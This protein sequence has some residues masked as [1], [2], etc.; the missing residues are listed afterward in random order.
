MNLPQNENYS[1]IRRDYEKEIGSDNQFLEELKLRASTT[2]GFVRTRVRSNKRLLTQ[3]DTAVMMRHIGQSAHFTSM[4]ETAGHLRAV[5]SKNKLRDAI[6]VGWGGLA[7]ESIDGYIQDFTVGHIQRVEGGMKWVEVLNA[8]FS[9]SVLALKPNLFAKQMVSFVAYAADIPVLD[10]AAGLADFAKNPAEAIRVMSES[11][12]I[13]KR[14]GSQEV[15]LAEKALVGGKKIKGALGRI[16]NGKARIDDV[17]M[18]MTKLGDRGAIYLGGWPVY[19]YNRD[20]LGKSPGQSLEA[21]EK[22]TAMTQQSTD[23]DQMSRFQA[24][25]NP[26]GRVF[27]MFMTAPLAYYRAQKRAIRQYSR[28]EINADNFAK[29][30]FIFNVLLPTLFQVVANGFAFGDDEEDSILAQATGIEVLPTG[31]ERAL[32]TG[33]I[34]GLLIVGPMIDSAVARAQGINFPDQTFQFMQGPKKTIDNTIDYF[35]GGDEADLIDILEGLGY[36]LGV[37]V[38]TV[39]NQAG[40]VQELLEGNISSGARRAAGFSEKISRKASGQSDGNSVKLGR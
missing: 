33:P 35:Q 19:K 22:A 2:P 32:I 30:M 5:F 3:S 17:F 15:A 13:Q 9:K 36:I 18:I 40:G 8:N 34:D 12:L 37:P 1:P 24:Q 31:T 39:M 23:L 25:K 14:A 10:F 20:V 26:I 4:A 6:T 38:E 29:K 16:A 27:S 28:G 11:A 21:F 7:R